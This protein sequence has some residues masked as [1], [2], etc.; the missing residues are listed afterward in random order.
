MSADILRS[1]GAI[2]LLA[3]G[4]CSEQQGAPAPDGPPAVAEAASE[5]LPPAS[6]PAEPRYVGRWASR[7]DLCEGGAWVFQRD[8]FGMEDGPMCDFTAVSEIT[9]GYRIDAQCEEPR[10]ERSRSSFTLRFSGSSRSGRPTRAMLVQDLASLP[11]TSLVYCG[12]A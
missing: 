1:I 10:G 4:A 7:A 2:A 9:G 8:S 12:P 11:E 3:L 5:Q 6:A